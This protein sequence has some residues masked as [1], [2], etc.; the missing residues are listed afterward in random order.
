[1]PELDGLR[2]IAILLVWVA[3]YFA[4]PGKGLV[5]PLDGYWFRLGW[6]GGRPVFCPLRGF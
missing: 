5:S 3:H 1:M 2:G 6:T 4:V